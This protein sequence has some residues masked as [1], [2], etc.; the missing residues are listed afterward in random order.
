[1]QQPRSTPQKLYFPASGTHFCQ[2]LNDPQGLVRPEG[3]VKLEK[4][5]TFISSG[6]EPVYIYI[7]II[8]EINVALDKET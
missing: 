3:L 1:M 8:F 5:N 4:K 2:R 7:Y 6:L